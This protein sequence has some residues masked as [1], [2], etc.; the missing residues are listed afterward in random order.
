MVMNMIPDLI[1]QWRLVTTRSHDEDGNP[2]RLPY[3][4]EPMGTLIFFANGRMMA[5]LCDGRSVIPEAELPREFVAYGGHYTFDGDRLS[6]RVDFTS[7]LP[8]MGTDQVRGVKYSD[9]LLTLLPPP[10]SFEGRTQYRELVW[11]KTQ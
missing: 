10:R 4:P 6:T 2:M 1:G 3:G 8:R 7:D 11:E 5:S 9:G